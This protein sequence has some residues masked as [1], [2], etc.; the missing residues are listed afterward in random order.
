MTRL[1]Q[2]VSAIKADYE[3]CFGCGLENPIG[4]HLDDFRIEGREVSASF[5]P[6]SF[7]RGFE[8]V[9]HGGVLAAALDEMLAWTAMLDQ[10]VFVLTG[11]L[12][13]RF[14]RPA[15]VSGTY[16]LT[17]RVDDRRGRRLTISGEC[18]RPD[19]EV[20]AEANGLF[21]ASREVDAAP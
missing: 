19:G 2:R 7:Y 14:R 6:R 8:D 11:K 9:L 1:D 18:R 4:L 15:P 17:G 3:E 5:T 20:V 10:G 16:Q 21:L 13:L 12:D